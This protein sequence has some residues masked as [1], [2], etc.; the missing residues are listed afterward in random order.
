MPLKKME[1]D[2]K[3]AFIQGSGK[4]V[5]IAPRASRVKRGDDKTASPVRILFFGELGSG[6]T[7]CIVALLQMGYKVLVISTDAGGSGLST[8]K[9]HLNNNNLSH[10]LEG[11]YEVVLNDNEEVQAFMD[12]PELFFPDIFDVGID[13]LFWDGFSNWQQVYLSEDI[14]KMPLERSGGKELGAA[15]ESGLFF[16]QGQWGMMRNGT[17]RTIDHFCSMNNRKTGQVWHKIVTAQESIKTKPLAEG[18]G[19][20]E[21]KEPLLQ[22]SGGI[23]TGAAFDLIIRTKRS[24]VMNGS[25]LVEKFLYQIKAENKRD[26]NRGFQLPNSMEADM[27]KLW[28]E[29]SR[30]LGL[31]KK[32]VDTKLI[33]TI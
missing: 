12:Y 32:A 9:L 21:T 20:I 33:E 17:V 14:G 8:V 29:I 30:Q 2:S 13:F 31:E 23:L 22:G 15:V 27:T 26:K 25:D 16:E 24:K 18:G 19:F 1:N 4:R 3:E 28:G 10:L 11:L 7:F 5:L 6:K